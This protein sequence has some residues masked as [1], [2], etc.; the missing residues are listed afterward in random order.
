MPYKFCS[1]KLFSF[2]PLL[3]GSSSICSASTSRKQYPSED[4]QAPH[5]LITPAHTPT[6]PLIFFNRFWAIHNRTSFAF[7]HKHCAANSYLFSDPL[8]ISDYS[9]HLSRSFLIVILSCEMLAK[10]ALAGRLV[11]QSV[12]WLIYLFIA[13][14][15]SK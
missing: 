11:G 10:S 13:S 6:H 3:Y 5:W 7:L 1:P 4:F 8:L 9:S 15:S 14:L 12:C 2:S